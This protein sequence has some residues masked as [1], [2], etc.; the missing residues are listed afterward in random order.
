MRYS[1]DEEIPD[2]KCTCTCYNVIMSCLFVASAV[3]D[4]FK[5]FALSM[6]TLTLK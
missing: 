2:P 4:I 6:L 3:F 5:H 1:V